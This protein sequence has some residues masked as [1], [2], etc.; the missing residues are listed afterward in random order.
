[1]KFRATLTNELP[2]MIELPDGEFEVNTSVG[3]VRLN[4]NSDWYYLNTARFAE[5]SGKDLYVGDKETLQ[6]IIQ[7]NGISNYAFSDCKSFVSCSFEEESSINEED[8]KNITDDQCIKKIKSIMVRNGTTYTDS[9]DLHIKANKQF[10][11]LPEKQLRSIKER[12]LKEARL[13]NLHK[14]YAYYDALNTLIR[15]YSYLRGHFWVHKLDSNILQGT[16]IQDYVDDKFYDSTT[17]AGLVPSIMPS[18]K[19]FPE[20]EPADLIALKGRLKNNTEMPIEDELILVARSLWYRLEYRSAVIES[21]AALEITVEKKLIEKMTARGMTE[22][23]IETELAKTETNFRQRCDVFLKRCTGTS[24][25]GDNT[26][27]WDLIDQHRKNYRHKIAHSNV[28]PNREKTE[29]IVNDFQ[30]A[31]EYVKSL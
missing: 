14:V 1:M 6:N 30:R 29:E 21:S 24:F 7:N 28:M 10:E 23:E 19:K 5:Y 2:F 11:K 4:I 13:A 17:F 31:I 20:I 15:H 12:I 3:I 25:V 22:A 9:D 18:K 16:L 27:L 26:T 8:F